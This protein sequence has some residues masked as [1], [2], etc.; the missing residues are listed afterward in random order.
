MIDLLTSQKVTVSTGQDLADLGAQANEAAAQAVFTLYQDRRPINTQRSQR[1]ALKTFAA[2]MRSAGIA[3]PDLYA[4]PW[5]WQGITWGLC[6]GFQFWQLKKGYSMKT[7]NDR[8]SIVK[9]YMTMAN[10]SGVIPDA[11]IL[12]LRGLRGFTR[13]ESIDMDEKRTGQEI[14]IRIGRKKSVATPITE[15]QA[16]QL[17]QV[18]IDTPQARRDALLMC[19]LLDHGLRVSEISSLAIEN[20]DLQ[21]KQMVFCRRKTGRVSRHNL[22][23]RAWQCLVEYMAKDNQTKSG[24]L[25]IASCKSGILLPG[26]GLTVR[27]INQRVLQLGRAV[28]LINLSPHDCRHYG[29]TKAG[30]DSAVSL[31]ALMAWGGWSSA[32]SAARYIDRGESD[33]DGV[34]LGM[35]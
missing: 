26:H 17:C 20:V 16:R 10:L 29:A 6:Q 21:T 24:P 19:I 15:E 11:E 8:L 31:G 34:S 25:F 9:V 12:R 18:R 7:I 27:A 33:N 28:G 4:D 2:Y 1:A 30:H 3:V 13:K 5:A 32:T 23:G 22:R 14:P 35:E